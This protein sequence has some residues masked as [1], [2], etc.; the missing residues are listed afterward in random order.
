[1]ATSLGYNI[2]R[3][4][5][6]QSFYV[7]QTTGCYVTKVDLYF[8]AKG[9]AAPV[10][11]QI[12]PM[13]NGFP[14]TSE[15][16]PSSTVYVNTA[17]VNTSSD[18]SLATSF[19][20]DEPIY[21]KGL[22]DYCVVCTTTD[23]NYFIYIAQIDEYV[24]G[25]TASRVNR[26]PALGSLFYSQN[27]GS[28]S[29]AQ[30]QDLTFVIHRANFTAT[31][32]TVI[33]KNTSLP[34]KLLDENPVETNTASTTVRITDEGHGFVVNDPVTILG[35]DSS[36]TIGGLA[37]TQIMGSKT[38]TAVDWTGYNITAGAAADSADIGGGLNVKVSKNI[39]WSVIY[40]NEQSL[41]PVGTTIFTSL[42]RTTGKSFAGTETPYQLD[43]EFFSLATNKTQ[44]ADNPKVVANTVIETAELGSNVKSFQLQSNFSTGNSFVSPMIDLQRSSATL[45]DYQ[46]DRQDSASTT[47]FNVPL[48]Y[49][50][51]TSARGGTAAAK[52][53][54]R[55]IKLAESAVGIK[56]LLAANKP[57][58]AYFDLYWRACA[59]DENIF[60]KDW[61]LQLTESNNPDARGMTTFREYEYLIG[62]TTGTLPQFENF[63]LK[64]V[65]HSTN[66]S[67]V[68]RIKDLRT[69]ALSV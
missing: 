18:V 40:L 48:S 68:A 24:V 66:R 52:H 8:Q 55:V 27:G 36:T 51:E 29:P 50:S 33:L 35:M 7:D 44:F 19:E 22:T 9:S 64:I 56:V 12:R 49:V 14:S 54:T 5:I 3:N 42:K 30:N 17:N 57:V 6:A 60:N 34:M 32:G 15:I 65:F 4:P 23:P 41:T 69:I 37:T 59:A 25:T 16:V 58:G 20:F 31:S 61:T 13:V 43:T 1:M 11:I 53:I 10:M 46:I 47:N 21:L 38:V 45:I 62:G 63:Q 2:S 67:K 28:F 39:P 26:N